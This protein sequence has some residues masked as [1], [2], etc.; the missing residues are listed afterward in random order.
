MGTLLFI[1]FKVIFSRN[2]ITCVIKFLLPRRL[3]LLQLLLVLLVVPLG[4]EFSWK[5]ARIRPESTSNSADRSLVCLISFSRSTPGPPSSAAS[6]FPLEYSTKRRFFIISRTRLN[7]PL[8]VFV[9]V[10]IFSGT[11]FSRWGKFRE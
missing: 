1:E 10:E 6:F 5:G 7:L 4:V 11:P 9:C 3:A 8:L 2:A